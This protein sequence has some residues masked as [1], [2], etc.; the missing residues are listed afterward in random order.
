MPLTLTTSPIEWP[1]DESITPPEVFVACTAPIQCVNTNGDGLC[2]VHCV[3]GSVHTTDIEEK[4]EF[5][6]DAY[7]RE[8]MAIIADYINLQQTTK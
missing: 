3:F 4:T 8:S 7:I 2:S 5:Q 1:L 6:A